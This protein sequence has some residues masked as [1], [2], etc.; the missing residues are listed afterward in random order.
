[1]VE[2][3]TAGVDL[4]EAR[5]HTGDSA[6]WAGGSMAVGSMAVGSMAVGSVAAEDLAEG[7]MAAGDLAAA[8]AVKSPVIAQW[9]R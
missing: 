7:S 4:L 8:V 5:T 2:F 6:E 9:L 1:M 3:S